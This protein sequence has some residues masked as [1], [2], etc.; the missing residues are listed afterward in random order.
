MRLS[1]KPAEPKP[2]PSAKVVTIVSP[3]P[4]TPAAD[5]LPEE[6]IAER[7]YEKWVNRGCPM[8]QDGEQDWYAAKDEL[9][10][11]RLHWATPQSE[12]RDRI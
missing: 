11:E 5:D 7:A 1:K 3:A 6:L 4:T 10:Q 9:E 8:G 2:K 12:D